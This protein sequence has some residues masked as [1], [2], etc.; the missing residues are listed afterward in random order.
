MQIQH[1]HILL[2]FQKPQH[3]R[4]LGVTWVI[5]PFEGGGSLLDA[6]AK[7]GRV[8]STAELIEV[9]VQLLSILSYLEARG[10]VHGDLKPGN[11][12]LSNC[13][14]LKV[15]DLQT[16]SLVTEI[17]K[18]P[19]PYTEGYVPPEFNL[20]DTRNRYTPFSSTMDVYS[21]GKT[22]VAFVEGH[23]PM[24]V[25]DFG[26]ESWT[27]ISKEA[28]EFIT[29][30]LVE[31]PSKRPTFA[32]LQQ[33]EFI[34]GHVSQPEILR[35]LI[36]EG[37]LAEYV[38]QVK[39]L[40]RS[41][42]TVPKLTNSGI[43]RKEPMADL[44]KKGV[45]VTIECKM[46]RLIFGYAHPSLTPHMISSYVAFINALWRRDDETTREGIKNKDQDQSEITRC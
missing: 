19:A 38:N 14:E 32:Q 39:T 41:Q 8:P 36:N 46:D 42:S 21:F 2:P 35:N 37:N 10:I 1:P 20:K 26:Q 27:A 40:S 29:L 12:V 30:C 6:R 34:A 16:M 33:H 13:G 15:I 23:T 3:L 45:A 44:W 11:T 31:E 17:R 25:V 18:L 5:L 4:D 43:I 22:L 28:Q 7:L 9:A 24:R